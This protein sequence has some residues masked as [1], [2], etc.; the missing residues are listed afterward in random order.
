MYIRGQS[1]EMTTTDCVMA[2]RLLFVN[3]NKNEW[4]NSIKAENIKPEKCQHT[5]TI[6]THTHTDDSGQ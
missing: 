3:N 6:A 5:P 2:K 4:K 1:K